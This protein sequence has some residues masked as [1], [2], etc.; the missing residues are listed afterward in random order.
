MDRIEQPRNERSRRTRRAVLDSALKLTRDH[1]PEAVTMERVAVDAGVSRRAMY[2]H[3]ASRV[4]L[5]VALLDHVDE[6]EDLAA[7]IRPIEE[8]ESLPAALDAMARHVASYHHRIMPL[9]RAIDH[10][11]RTDPAA[12][13]LHDRA[14]ALWMTGCRRFAEAAAAA[15]E[16]AEPWDVDT[17]ADL[18]W[19]L[20][21]VEL[22]EDL[23]EDRG[24]SEDLYGERLG[25]LARRTLLRHPDG[26]PEGPDAA[27]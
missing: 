24:W 11:R 15:G 6:Q 8:A 12:A 21:G 14:M 3:F 7:S 1:G 23:Q 26:A 17:A 2:L 16:L 20:M 18:L 22:L 25:L 13:A 4:E 27:S 5:M 9:V 10:A 19:A